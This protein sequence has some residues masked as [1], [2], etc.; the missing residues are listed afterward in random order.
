MVSGSVSASC[1]LS[2]GAMYRFLVEMMMPEAQLRYLDDNLVMFEFMNY[3]A[4]TA[5]QMFTQIKIFRGPQKKTPT[6]GFLTF[7]YTSKN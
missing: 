6:F 1:L 3:F 2:D 5:L 7:Q 4:Y